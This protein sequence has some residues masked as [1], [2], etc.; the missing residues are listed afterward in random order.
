MPTIQQLIRSARKKYLKKQNPLLYNLVH[1]DEV[2]VLE[3][4]LLLQKSPI[5][6]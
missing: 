6:H 1:N 2:F 4:I 5:Q 3:F